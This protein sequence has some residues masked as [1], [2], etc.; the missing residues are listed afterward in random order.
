M[1]FNGLCYPESFTIQSMPS[2]ILITQPLTQGGWNILFY[3]L[4]TRPHT[5][6]RYDLQ[7][8]QG[9]KYLYFYPF[10]VRAGVSMMWYVH[11]WTNSDRTEHALQQINPLITNCA[12]STA[13]GIIFS[14]ER[15][16]L[17]AGWVTESVC[18]HKATCFTS[19]SSHTP[20]STPI[21]QWHNSNE[22]CSSN[23]NPLSTPETHLK[24][25]QLPSDLA[26]PTPLKWFPA[27]FNL[28][29]FC[30]SIHL[31]GLLIRPGFTQ[32]G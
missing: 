15:Q 24:Y 10:S 5:I 11:V 27:C 29:I 1:Y 3:Q 26:P 20:Q 22:P 32:C 6:C 28:A 18:P 7:C 23:M 9:V 25:I 13:N 30:W 2:F 17:L 12:D 16:R 14:T 4:N 19:S 31:I 21:C 8:V